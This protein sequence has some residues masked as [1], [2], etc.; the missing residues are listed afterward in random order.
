MDWMA[1]LGVAVK[2]KILV[3]AVQEI[4]HQLLHLK[5]AMVVLVVLLLAAEVV[6]VAV[7]LLL[8]LLQQA[9]LAVLAVLV[10]LH[11]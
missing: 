6:A 1:V 8:E 11:L 10:Q 9:R 2:A 5:V 4:P 3:Q 7:L